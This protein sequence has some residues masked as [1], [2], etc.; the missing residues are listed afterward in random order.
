MAKRLQRPTPPKEGDPDEP[1][2]S[3]KSIRRDTI[4]RNIIQVQS[5]QVDE[6]D[7][8]RNF[9]RKWNS[10]KELNLGQ[11]LSGKSKSI[12]EQRRSIARASHNQTSI[13][14]Q[15][16]RRNDT[17]ASQRRRPLP[18][19]PENEAPFIPPTIVTTNPNTS[20]N[21][22]NFTAQWVESTTPEVVEGYPFD[23]SPPPNYLG[24]YGHDN[25]A[26]DTYGDDDEESQ[27]IE[28]QEREGPQRRASKSSAKL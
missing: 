10:D 17:Y 12:L 15:N 2:S 8:E 26:Y 21:K 20:T 22:S 25:Y 9:L 19:T 3:K 18:P 28:L 7:L 13:S 11:S 1:E 5:N 14:N 24:R 6:S 16:T 4:H 27:V 23:T